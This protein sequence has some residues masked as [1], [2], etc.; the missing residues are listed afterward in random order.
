MAFDAFEALHQTGQILDGLF[1][2]LVDN[3]ALNL[4]LFYGLTGR[5]PDF[6]RVVGIDITVPLAAVAVAMYFWMAGLLNRVPAREPGGAAP[7]PGRDPN[8]I[9]RAD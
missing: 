9:E 1:F 7:A 4:L 2:V 3:D 6:S 8:L 5:G